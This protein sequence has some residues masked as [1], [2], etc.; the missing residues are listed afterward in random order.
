[1][2]NLINM[3]G[4]NP[5]VSSLVIANEFGRQHKIVIKNIES[6]IESEHIGGHE[7]VLTSYTDNSNRQSKYYELTEDGFLI[8]MPFIGGRKSK[9]GQRALVKE[10]SKYRRQAELKAQ[11]EWQEAR[12]AGKIARRQETGVIELYIDY[13]KTQG[14][15]RANNYYQNL[16]KATY[17]ALFLVD[18]CMTGI[19]EQLDPVQLSI[20]TTAEHLA[21]QSLLEG[22][23]R[24]EPYKKIY[25]TTR[26][27]L[28]TLG[29]LIGSYD[30]F[31]CM[32]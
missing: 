4:N 20:L 8:A 29:Y 5:T 6:L 26:D 25:T 9:D 2:Q 28:Q 32:T 10:F 1:M 23:E 13:A 7:F 21:K 12:A 3:S 17:K 16:T 18:G 27:S 15:L 22:M 19:R 11:G 14:S 31:W 30:H 24:G